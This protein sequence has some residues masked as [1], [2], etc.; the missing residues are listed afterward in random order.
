MN[1]FIKQW[2]AAL[3]SGRYGQIQGCLHTE[4]GFCCIGVG[5]D[6]VNST[7]W[8]GNSRGFF[9]WN[10]DAVCASQELIDVTG[11]NSSFFGDLAKLND[12]LEFTFPQI[13]DYI[14]G[15]VN[16]GSAFK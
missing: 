15:K 10:G 5:C 2:L 16:N 6:L 9:E 4:K 3:R 13:A 12:E 7:R 8:V 1:D 14:E 11:F